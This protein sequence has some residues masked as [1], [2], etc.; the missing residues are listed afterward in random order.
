MRRDSRSS[1]LTRRREFSPQNGDVDTIPAGLT[2]LDL[3]GSPRELVSLP[4]ERPLLV[5]F[6]RHFG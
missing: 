3:E 6:L 2:V 5:A 4:A 1:R